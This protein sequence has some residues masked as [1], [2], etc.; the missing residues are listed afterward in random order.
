MLDKA[1]QQQNDF[2]AAM[3]ENEESGLSDLPREVQEK[4]TSFAIANE[5]KDEIVYKFEIQ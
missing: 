3:Q 1:E 5:Y 2:A 4:V